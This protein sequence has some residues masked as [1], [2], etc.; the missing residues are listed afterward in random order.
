MIILIS[1]ALLKLSDYEEENKNFFI[2]C[3]YF[4]CV[5]R[6]GVNRYLL[7][8]QI[9]IFYMMRDIPIYFNIELPSI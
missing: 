7:I 5:G 4:Y 3:C 6:F 1:K 2:A 8:P 9:L